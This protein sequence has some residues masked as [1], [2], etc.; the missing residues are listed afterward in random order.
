[1]T[2]VD[3]RRTVWAIEA[4]TTIQGDANPL[5]GS[6]VVVSLKK[7]GGSWRNYLLT[8]AHVVKSFEG[9]EKAS[10][11]L[12]ANII[13]R[14][15]F[16][17]FVRWESGRKW[18]AD[19]NDGIFTG[20]VVDLFNRPE[21]EWNKLDC[22][23]ERDWVLIE[24][25][26]TK[27]QSFEFASFIDPQEKPIEFQVVGYPD[28]VSDYHPGDL[29]MP[30]RSQGLRLDRESNDPFVFQ[31]DGGDAT[32]GGMSGGGLFESDGALVGVY[33]GQTK[34]SEVRYAVDIRSVCVELTR[35]NFEYRLAKP[36]K[37]STWAVVDIVFVAVYLVFVL[38]L[39]WF[40][41]ITPVWPQTSL[42]CVSTFLVC[43][44]SMFVAK[45]IPIPRENW[46]YL[47]IALSVSMTLLFLVGLYYVYLRQTLVV[48]F[49]DSYVTVG[50]DNTPDSLLEH[51]RS[52]TPTPTDA[53]GYLEYFLKPE[54]IWTTEAL[55]WSTC[56]LYCSWMV[57]MAL[58][59]TLFSLG[60]RCLRIRR[61]NLP[62]NHLE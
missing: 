54:E 2:V 40:P 44:A 61:L 23:R 36:R 15:P 1:M 8:C 30:K 33:F 10:G 6:G 24:I 58:L 48:W 32:A 47:I 16:R 49:T 20:K 55:G 56:V 19:E 17:G 51:A 39:C 35:N 5:Q 12:G 45:L 31:L 50:Y 28:G 26:E 41:S 53:I 62:S 52:F 38:G 14:P 11:P 13:A 37:K 21:G 9:I 57:F 7:E 42:L 4:H 43:F 22:A 18:P 46:K 34:E 25:S 3:L 59:S 29:L 60:L 27:F